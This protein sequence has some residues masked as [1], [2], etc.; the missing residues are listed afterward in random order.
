MNK[1]TTSSDKTES[2]VNEGLDKTE[3]N[4]IDQNITNSELTNELIIENIEQEPR[5]STR[6]RNMPR[7]SYKE[8]NDG[9]NCYLAFNEPSYYTIEEQC[10]HT[11]AQIIE[12]DIPES[13]HDINGRNDQIQWEEAIKEELKSLNENQTW[14]IVQMPKNKNIVDCKWVLTIKNDSDGNLTR[15]KARLVAKGFI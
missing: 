12:N 8:I 4:E 11:F 14:E 15:Y 6:I 10:Y 13:Y 2:M 9:Q 5:K 7:V 3:V 1:N